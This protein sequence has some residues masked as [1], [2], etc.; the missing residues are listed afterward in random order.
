MLII[1]VFCHASWRKRK[2]YK[3]ML[4]EICNAK[5]QNFSLKSSRFRLVAVEA[6]VNNFSV[7]NKTRKGG[8][9]AAYK[10][11]K[12][13]Y[14]LVIG[15]GSEG[16]MGTIENPILVFVSLMLILLSFAAADEQVPD[17]GWLFSQCDFHTDHKSLDA[18]EANV[19]ALLSDLS[20]KAAHDNGFSTR[21][22]G[23]GTENSISGQILCRGDV[24][25]STCQHG[26][27]VAANKTLRQCPNGTQFIAYYD[28][29]MLRYTSKSFKFDGLIGEDG[30]D[31][32]LNKTEISDQSIFNQTVWVLLGN[33]TAKAAN[34]NLPDKKFA[35]HEVLVSNVSKESADLPDVHPSPPLVPLAPSGKRHAGS[36]IIAVVIV[37]AIVISV[38][39]FCL[40]SCYLLRRKLQRSQ[41]SILTQ[42]F[43]K[44]SS[45]LKSLR[46][47]LATIK[48]ATNNFSP[49][50]RIGK[51]GFGH[52]YKGILRD[53]QKIAVKRLS[54]NSKQ[55][56]LEFKNEVLL[57]AKL[58]HRNLVTL[59]GFCLEEQEKILVYEYVPNKSIDFFLFD[60]ENQRQLNWLK[61][62]KII[63]GIA[64]DL[65]YLHDHSCLKV[66]HH[67]L[68]PSNV[69]LDTKIDPKIS[70]FGM[71]RMVAIDQD[72]ENT[73][74]IV[75]P[76]SFMSPEYLLY[77]Q[78][79]KK[80]DVF[81]FGVMVLEIIS[82]KRNAKLGSSGMREH[83]YKY[84]A[85][86]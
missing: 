68:K 36:Q 65:L 52:V 83:H 80:S 51:G 2:I 3:N 79:S 73:N 5:S 82:S 74:R 39:L 27:T 29:C 46:F 67:D 7:E 11:D 76:Y 53:G 12:L 75:R 84:W 14:E 37:A 35:T 8:F 47:N 45:K 59:L 42:N 6:E 24:T 17:F 69:L 4:K 61:Q 13:I 72:Q 57:I 23:W 30:G 78:I 33:V 43:G 28:L 1:A 71:V 31:W 20:S 26:V 34:S 15:I 22:V 66:I 19:R 60:S 25:P 77:G 70:D 63:G 18:Y 56:A 58:Q 10:S 64:R 40:M 55:G 54:K 62:C 9:R 32:A 48:T 44:E 38:T 86:A 21:V 85:H 81:S 16:Y 41:Q 49:Q 50:N